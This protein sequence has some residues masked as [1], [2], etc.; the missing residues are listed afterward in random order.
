MFI[1]IT[2]YLIIIKDFGEEDDEELV[3][4]EKMAHSNSSIPTS[5][6]NISPLGRAS[7]SSSDSKS[8]LL[9]IIIIIMI[10]NST[11]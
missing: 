1:N 3:E 8:M 7:V 2:C 10:N 11:N 6:M 4:I 9:L 5:I